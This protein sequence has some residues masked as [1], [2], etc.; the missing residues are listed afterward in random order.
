M[1]WL[2]RVFIFLVGTVYG[3]WAFVVPIAHFH[4]VYGASG[5]VWGFLLFYALVPYLVFFVYRLI[6]PPKKEREIDSVSDRNR[7]GLS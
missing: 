6:V 7:S 2:K 5:L 3:P 1:V 4:K